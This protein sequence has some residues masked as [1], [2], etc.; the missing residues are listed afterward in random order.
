MVALF[1]LARLGFVPTVRPFGTVSLL[2]GRDCARAVAHAIESDH[3]SGHYYVAEPEPVS[4]IHMARAIAKTAGHRRVIP[5][6]PSL[7]RGAGVIG[8]WVGRQRGKASMLN[9]DKAQDLIAAHQ[10]CDPSR[11]MRVL[12][13]TPHDRFITATQSIA[14]AYRL[15]GWL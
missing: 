10:S 7:V 5:L 11:A 6:P 3:R 2:S 13:W 4:R 14:R 9:R 8:E 15:R 1:R 12:K